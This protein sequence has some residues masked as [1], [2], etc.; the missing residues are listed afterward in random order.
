M[1][2]CPVYSVTQRVGVKCSSFGPRGQRVSE[3]SDRA[4]DRTSCFFG[5]SIPKR[6]QTREGLRTEG[7]TPSHH[8]KPADSRSVLD[9]PQRPINGQLESGS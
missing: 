4:E 1:R 6:R 8:S 2:L 3:G 5:L 7:G 9:V